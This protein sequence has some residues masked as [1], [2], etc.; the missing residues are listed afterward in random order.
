MESAPQRPGSNDLTSVAGGLDRTLGRA[1]LAYTDRP[2]DAL[3]VLALEGQQSPD[4]LDRPR[5]LSRADV[6][7]GH[8]E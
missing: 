6:L 4:H 2:L 8:P 3:E 1:G 7:G 5:D